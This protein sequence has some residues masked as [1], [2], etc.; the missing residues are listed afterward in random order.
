MPRRVRTGAL[1]ALATLI[2][3]GGARGADDA[4]EID[5][6]RPSV[7]VSGWRTP[8][9]E[10]KDV[11]GEF[12]QSAVAVSAIL[13]LGGTRIDASQGV[14]GRQFFLSARLESGTAEVGFLGR[15]PQLASGGLRVDGLFLG[16][17]GNLYLAGVG[18]SFAEDTDG[19]GGVDPRLAAFGLATRRTQG[20]T[21]WLYGAAFSYAY[22]RPLVLPL[23]GARWRLSEDWSLLAALPFNARA[24]WRASDRLALGFGI[25][26]RGNRFRID[27]QGS[28]PGEPEIVYMRVGQLATTAELEYRP[29]GPAGRHAFLVEAGS[30]IARRITFDRSTD[31]D[32]TI[33]EADLEPAGILRLGWRVQFGKS[34]LDRVE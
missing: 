15:D 23:L 21:L 13:P 19:E 9:T 4:F 20:G 10:Y 16:R 22:G 14:S 6:F 18:A 33:V 24:R 12:G 3:W 26:P 17:G 1:I 8:E 34:L 2:C 11:P 5:L 25:A 27:N 7:E 32:D 29:A 28:F 31:V 30:L